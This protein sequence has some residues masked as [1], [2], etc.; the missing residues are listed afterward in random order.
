MDAMNELLSYINYSKR[1]LVPTTR[2]SGGDG[3]ACARTAA[4]KPKCSQRQ[5]DTIYM[6]VVILM[7][8]LLQCLQFCDI[9]QF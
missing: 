7:W 9:L 6:D 1:D 4:I 5:T 2:H 3:D 8:H